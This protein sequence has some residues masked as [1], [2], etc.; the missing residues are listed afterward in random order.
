MAFWK[1][2]PSGERDPRHALGKRGEEEAARYL[3]KRGYEI[4]ERNVRTRLG[5]IDLIARDG[6][7]LVFVEVKTRSSGAFAPPEL[8]VDGRK[9]RKLLDLAHAHLGRL[10]EA[11]DCR[12]DVL[13]LVLRPGRRPVI[14]H[15]QNAF[16]DEAG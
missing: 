3:Q 10:G 7:V 12:F 8:A 6:E 15:I 14:H 16:Q 11:V 2:S 1:K 4:V 9:R 5:E 13:G